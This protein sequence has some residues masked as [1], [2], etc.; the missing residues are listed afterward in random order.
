MP[1]LSRF[2]ALPSPFPDQP[3]TLH[4]LEA[5][6]ASPGS[7]RQQLVDGSYDKPFLLEN[8][9]TRSLLFS[10]AYIQSSMRLDAPEALDLAYTERMMAFLLFHTNVKRLLLLGLG[11]GSLAKFCLRHL[12][13]ID[14]TA[15]EADARVL[16]FREA[17]HIPPDSERFRVVVADAAAYV[18]NTTG[19]FDV[20]LVDAFDAEGFAPSVSAPGFYEQAHRRLAPKGVLVANLA[21][22]REARRAH[23]EFLRDACGDN[24][25]LL[26]IDDDC[27]DIAYAFHEAR[28]EPRWKWIDSQAKAMR[29]RYGIDFPKIAARLERSWRLGL[30]A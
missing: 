9:Q 21:G 4:L 12:P 30:E 24:L 26:P 3:G 16:A 23:L 22:E 11:G 1:D 29:A 2:L 25:L 14:L 28:F 6:D 20:I 27:N 19:R 17:F 10:L 7:L 15:V 8:G 5:S 18:A 13:G